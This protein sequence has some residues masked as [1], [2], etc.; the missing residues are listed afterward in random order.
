[1]DGDGIMN[2]A[3]WNTKLFSGDVLYDEIFSK[4]KIPMS[5]SII[6]GETAPYGLYGKFATKGKDISSQLE[7]IAKK[8]FALDNVEPASHTFTHPFFWGKIVNDDLDPRYRLKVKNY[9]FSIDREI[10]GSLS[11]ITKKLSPKDKKAEMIFWSGDC[12]P[13]E[14]TLKYMYKNNFLHINGGDTTITYENPWL[15]TVAPYG[16]KRG[17]YHQIFTGAQNENVFTNDWLGPYWGFKKVI[18]TFEL[19]DKPKRFKPIDIYFHT[20]SGSKKASKDA[21]HTVFQW[22]I[23]QDVMPIYTS[24][25]IPKVLDFYDISLAHENNSWLIEGAR[26]LKT[27]RVDRNETVDYRASKGIV[28]E[29][30]HE[31]QKYIHLDNHQKHLLVLDTN[32]SDQ[33]YLIDANAKLIDTKIEKNLIYLHFKGNVPVEIKYHLAD[34]CKLKTSL[35]PH[36]KRLK[37]GVMSIVYKKYKDVSIEIGCKEK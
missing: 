37:D 6:E 35:R 28:G 29:K 23:K 9:D 5:L 7:N 22:A 26:D 20:Y 15:S 36:K 1:M 13:T 8:I 30:V 32:N 10:N 18:Q 16:I 11:Y 25:Y 3:E 24:E 19:T 2:R 17:E 4:Y 21:L 31:S 34:G 33:N 12:L 27:V 14:T